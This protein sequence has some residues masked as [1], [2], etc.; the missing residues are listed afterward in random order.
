MSKGAVPQCGGERERADHLQPSRIRMWRGLILICAVGAIL[1]ALH[2]VNRKLLNIALLSWIGLIW[3]GC[4]MLAWERKPF[5]IG[6]CL[7]PVVAVIPFCLPAGRIDGAELRED[8]LRRMTQFEGTTYVWGGENSLGI[9]CSGL[10]RRALRDALLANGVRH[11]NGTAFRSCI[12]QWWFD[13]SARALGKGYR[14]YTQPLAP[15]GN[16]REMEYEFLVPGDLA[17]TVSGVHILV[18][19]GDERRIQA[20]PKIGSVAT[21]NGRSSDNDWF[22]TPVTTHRWQLFAERE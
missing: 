12:E 4:L 14:D 6:V 10:P 7:V 17:V 20:D 18:Y 16:I 3:F 15:K 9:D 2:P 11:A 19:A 5:L 22:D 8:Y 21:L 1:T 13:A